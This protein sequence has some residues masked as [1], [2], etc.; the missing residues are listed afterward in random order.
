MAS[1]EQLLLLVLASYRLTHLLVF[2]TIAE[3][4]RQWADRYAWLGELIGCYWCCGIWVSGALVGI[5]ILWPAPVRV[6]IIILAV[7]G[8]QALIETLVERGKRE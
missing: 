8:G 4:L 5:Q 2:D 6:A 1:W 7:A 3:P